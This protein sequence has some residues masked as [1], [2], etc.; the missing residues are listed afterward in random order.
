MFLF[1]MLVQNTVKHSPAENE[2]RYNRDGIRNRQ[3]EQRLDVL[4]EYVI[5]RV[6]HGSLC[7]S[8]VNHKISCNN[9]IR[10]KDDDE[11]EDDIGNHTIASMITISNITTIDGVAPLKDTC[12]VESIKRNDE[13][14]PKPDKKNNKINSSISKHNIIVFS[15]M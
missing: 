4:G 10:N 14:A 7:F 1:N 11:V 15:M 5:N 8:L 3:G 9:S 2:S 12:K 6:I 13:K